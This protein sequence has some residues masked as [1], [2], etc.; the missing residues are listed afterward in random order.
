MD[1]AE[2]YKEQ[3]DGWGYRYL[4][5]PAGDVRQLHEMIL[6]GAGVVHHVNNL[7][8]HLMEGGLM[9]SSVLQ[10][11][12][13]ASNPPVRASD[14]SLGSAFGCSIGSFNSSQGNNNLITEL[15]LTPGLYQ[16]S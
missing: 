5:P 2:Q 1:R 11:P 3:T 7:K 10:P 9:W 6:G 15:C 4:S 14:Q 8:L 13:P 16:R 12:N